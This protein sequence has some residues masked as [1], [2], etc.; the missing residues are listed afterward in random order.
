MKNVIFS[1]R[2]PLF[3]AEIS[4]NHN[5]KIQNAK[6]LIKIAKANG[7]DFVKLQTYTPEC[8]TID[9]DEKNFQIKRG[10]WKGHS[11][12]SLY[13]KAQTPLSWHKELFKYS[14]RLGIKCF[15]SPFSESM[16][17]FLESLNCPLYKLASFELLHAPLIKR[18]A[19]TKKPII[20]STGMAN[21]K[22]LD[23]AVNT[24]RKNGAKKI[25]ILYCVSNYPSKTSD[26]NLNNI[27]ILKK[28]YK[29]MIGFSD[30][31]QDNRVA[32]AAVAAGA[33]IVEKH[34]ALEK[35]KSSPDYIFSLKENEIKKFKQDLIFSKTLL[36]KSIFYRN[37]SESNSLQFRRSI[38]SKK[39]IKKGEKFTK[40]NLQII[41]PGFGL[42]P[43][44]YDNL[45]KMKSTINIKKNK[46]L[47]KKLFKIL[48]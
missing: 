17:D 36:G 40:K 2:Q 26:F 13:K 46:P 39:D 20:I 19:K 1:K 5:G 30:H 37:H 21:L 25:I 24:A 7:A 23:F 34:I 3:I 44:F 9:S 14:K 10:V 29:C 33:E 41:R 35:E 31:S 32:F 18:I 28:R 22:E 38:Y 4:A 45:L 43:M 6:K 16:V 8:M 12:W 11:L 48:K 15:S 27:S 47:S 42:S